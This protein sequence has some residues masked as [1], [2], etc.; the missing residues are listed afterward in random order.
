MVTTINFSTTTLTPHNLTEPNFQ[1]AIYYAQISRHTGRVLVRV[2]LSLFRYSPGR[3]QKGRLQTYSV[4]LEGVTTLLDALV[5]VKERVDPTVAFRYSCRMASCGSC[6]M[7]VNGIPRLACHTLISDIG[8]SR[9]RVEPLDNFRV[10]RDLMIDFDEF[11]DAHRSLRPFPVATPPGFER[12]QTEEELQRYVQ[13]TQCIMCGLCSSTCPTVASDD[14]Y[15]GPQ[16]IAQVFRFLIDPRDAAFKDR[17]DSIDD[18]HGAWRCHFA[19]SCSEVCPKAVD[20][21]LA[22]QLIRRRLIVE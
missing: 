6:G 13:F 16:A 20:P 1:K 11:F 14:M 8:S 17:L 7:K 10:L 19:G 21:A 22:I 18:A 5:Y 4:P 15:P 12:R 3:E 2:E 9:I